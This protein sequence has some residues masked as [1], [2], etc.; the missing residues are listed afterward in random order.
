MY[1]SKIGP[2]RTYNAWLN[3]K[4]RVFGCNY[5]KN[6][7]FQWCFNNSFLDSDLDKDHNFQWCNDRKQR[8]IE[9]RIKFENKLEDLEKIFPDFIHFKDNAP[10]NDSKPSRAPII[11][12]ITF[13]VI[14]VIYSI[15]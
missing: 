11:C 8:A 9:K 5:L 13:I 1:H 6:Y 10:P 2:H 7:N 3:F 14:I 12:C 15:F 4:L